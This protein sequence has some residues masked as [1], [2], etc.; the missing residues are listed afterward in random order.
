M[1]GFNIG[2]VQHCGQ[3]LLPSDVQPLQFWQNL[4]SALCFEIAEHA[5]PCKQV[6]KIPHHRSIRVHT[7][8]VVPSFNCAPI[9]IAVAK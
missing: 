2:L 7:G 9:L 6:Q 1:S 8:V 4:V 5:A 3:S